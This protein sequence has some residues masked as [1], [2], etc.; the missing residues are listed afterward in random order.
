MTHPALPVASKDQAYWTVS[1]LEAGKLNVPEMLFVADG[2]PSVS[3]KCPS[4]AF[5]LTHSVSGKT[6]VFDLGIRKDASTYPPA[7]QVLI[8]QFFT[9]DVQRD[10]ADS[11]RSGGVEPGTI[12][13]V[14]F[15]HFHYDHVGDPTPFVRATFLAGA[16]GRVLL[17]DGYPANPASGFEQNLLPRDRTLF[18]GFQHAGPVGPFARALDFFQDGSLHVVDAPG[19]VPGHI[20]LLVRMHGGH[21]V[22]L[23]GDTCH[24]LRILN[25]ERHICVFPDGQSAHHD[26]QA[27]AEHVAKVRAL[28]DMYGVRVILAHEYK[29]DEEHMDEYFPRALRPSIRAAL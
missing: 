21:W 4:L 19:H 7:A 9:L 15:S 27:A 24:D 6:L 11:L 2:D 13:Y 12:D 8:E 20:N 3:R 5:L 16:G 22:Y 29:W 18:L 10:V 1:A 23:G 26:H 28:R 14:A 25:G 17:D